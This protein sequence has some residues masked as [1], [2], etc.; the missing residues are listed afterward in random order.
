M[1]CGCRLSPV[2][3]ATLEPLYEPEMRIFQVAAIIVAGML[4]SA[5]FLYLRY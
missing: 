1:R 2:R 4:I 5:A 3:K